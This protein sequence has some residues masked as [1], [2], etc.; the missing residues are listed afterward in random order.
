MTRFLPTLCKTAAAAFVLVAAPAFA[1][2]FPSENITLVVPAAAGGSTD[3]LSRN[4]ARA[5]QDQTGITVIVDNKA[6]AGGAIGVNAVARAKPD[7]YTLVVSVLDAITVMPHLRKDM[8]YDVQKDLTHV[9]LIAETPWVFSVNPKVPAKSIEEF[10]KLAS[11]KPGSMK[12]SSQG[13]GTSGHLVVEMLKAHAKL[14][15]L[16][17]PYKGA[18]PAT[19]AAIGGEVDMVATSPL[20]LRGFLAGGQLRGLGMTAAERSPMLPD[21][22][23]MKESGYPEF[24]IS[25]WFGVFAPAGLPEDRAKT[26]AKIIDD[27]T[28]HPDMLKQFE[29]AG[30]TARPLYGDDFRK[31]V[32]NDSANWKKVIEGIN[33]TIND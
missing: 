30:L 21:I 6:G 12:F 27:A 29:T 24:V 18:G 17:V 20:T 33:L 19:T 11:A 14:D 26:L 15:M 16:H 23:T 7:G 31:Y 4:L 8:P 1:Q 9:A 3:L 25:A 10:V 13:V 32:E 22:P 5:I 28:K 2:K